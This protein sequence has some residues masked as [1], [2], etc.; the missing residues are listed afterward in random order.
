MTGTTG[1]RL[2]EAGLSSAAVDARLALLDRVEAALG[3]MEPATHGGGP[4]GALY[5]PGRIEVLG[6]HTDYA[7]GRSLVCACE[8][9]FV[10]RWRARGDQR[11]VAVD[12][13]HGTRV[14]VPSPDEAGAATA[15]GGATYVQATVRRL[16][17]H[18]PCA[19]FG[20]DLAFGSDLP[21]AAGLS[22]SSALVVTVALA[23]IEAAGLREQPP[24]RAHIAGDEDLAGYLATIENGLGFGTL[25]GDGGVGTFGGSEDHV[26]ILTSV[27][28]A[29]GQWR[30]CP[31]QL[32]R[33]VRLPPGL[34][35]VVAA[36]GVAAEKTGAALTRYNRASLLAA[37]LVATWNRVTGRHDVTLAGVFDSGPEALTEMRAIVAAVVD[38]GELRRALL[39]RLDQFAEES[40][41]IVPAAS[42]ALA[43]GDLETFGLFVLRSH[44]A[45]ARGL[46][47]VVPE[48]EALTEMARGEGAHAASPFGAGFGGSVWALVDHQRADQFLAAWRDRYLRAFA[49]HAGTATFFV[50]GAGPAAMVL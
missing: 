35:F 40:L 2:R 42:A 1:R 12:A 38:D 19:P 20:L 34:T 36:S 32:E 3:A 41:E 45:A 4:E 46:A 8:R 7:G 43:R 47:N 31:I 17:R 26:A 50:T 29:L 39:A 16:R 15:P 21:R 23:A 25:P 37:D 27:A 6:K 48:T 11:V 10:A 9:G 5:V 49:A 13:V 22:S 18:F 30:F 14:E 33:C 44:L 28:G 24:W